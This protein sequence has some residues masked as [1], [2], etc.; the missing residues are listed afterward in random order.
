M[1]NNKIGMFDSGIGG[2]TILK[3][4]RKLL[5]NENYIYYADSKN[6][7]YGEKSDS[8]LMN[9]VTNIVDFLISKEVKIIVIACN[10]ATTRCI[11]RLR[12]MYP[13]MIFVGTEPAIKVACD[14]NYKN[15]LVMATPGTIKS[16]RTHELVKLNKKRD[17][18]ITLLSC[19]GLADA[20]ES[21]NKDNVNKVLHKLLDK[22]VDEGIDSIVLGCT[23]Y[24]HA[25]KN[26]KELFPNAKLIDGNKGVS[27]QVKRQLESHNLLNN[28]TTRGKVKMIYNK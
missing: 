18:K 28:S 4:L 8:E 2:L 15:T 20:I 5:P 19:K 16:E 14:K 27:R 6:N 9:I 3:E 11:N 17:Q 1:N 21:G 12:K 22:Y 24:P 25:K 7:P 26:I 23:H 13:N 10:T